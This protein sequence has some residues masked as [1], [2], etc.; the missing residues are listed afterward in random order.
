MSFRQDG[1]KAHD[2]KHWLKAHREDILRCGL[3][4]SVLQSAYHWERF[5]EEGYDQ[6]TG[7]S[8]TWLSRQEAQAL[9]KFIF[10]EYGNARR[11]RNDAEDDDRDSTRSLIEALS[12]DRRTNDGCTSPCALPSLD[13]G[14]VRSL[15]CG[16][17]DCVDDARG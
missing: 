15:V 12:D 9:H 8:L 14:S 5:L 11:R 7:W 2:W 3:P 13:D 4:D 17:G 6:W 16:T 10:R 1:K